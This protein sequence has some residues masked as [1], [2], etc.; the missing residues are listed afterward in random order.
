MELI[1]W[2]REPKAPLA[3]LDEHWWPI[4]LLIPE[5][6]GLGNNGIHTMRSSL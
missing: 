6:L 5:S 1:R 3:V 4:I 2:M